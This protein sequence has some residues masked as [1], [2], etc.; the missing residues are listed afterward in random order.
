MNRFRLTISATVRVV[1]WAIAAAASCPQGGVAQNAPPR[2]MSINLCADQL[3]LALVPAGRITSVTWLAHS[4]DGSYLSAAAAHVAVNYGTAEEVARQHPDVVIAGSYTTPAT[5]ALLQRVGYHVIELAPVESFEQIR[6][7]TREVG[8]AVGES[9]KAEALIA[10]MDAQL[11]RLAANPPDKPW[12]V[13]AWNGTGFSPGRGTLYD[14]IL[15]A[16]GA[17]NV[18]A[19]RGLTNYN[20]FDT[21]ALLMSAPDVLIQGAAEFAKPGRSTDIDRH[22][23]VR[24]LWAGRRILI[25]QSLYVCGT[26]FSADAAAQ[27]RGDLERLSA[28]ASQPLSFMRPTAP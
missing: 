15:T 2:V 9:A 27:L 1:V 23:L 10:R 5:R 21:E 11:R 19:E 26:P 12:R 7:R 14:A 6:A 4:S 17:R 13:A 20:E 24:R 3:V 8:A 22:P 25:P 28:L 18:A 16:A